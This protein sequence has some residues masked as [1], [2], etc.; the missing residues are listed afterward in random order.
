[1]KKDNEKANKTSEREKEVK[2]SE[3]R[4]NKTTGHPTYIYAKVGKRYKYIGITH[5]EITQGV[6]NIKLEDNP[7][8]QDNGNAYIRPR[9]KEDKTKNF[10]EKKNGWKF[11]DRDKPKVKSVIDRDNKK[12]KKERTRRGRK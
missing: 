7:N 10:K 9:V 4:V 8:P 6:K 2:R 11:S 12:I 5:A 1:M 3:F